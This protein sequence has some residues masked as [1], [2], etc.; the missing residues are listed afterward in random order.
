MRLRNSIS[1]T[2]AGDITQPETSDHII[3]KSVERFSRV[4]VLVNNAGIFQSKPFTEYSLEEVDA[5]LGYLR[6]TFI[7]MK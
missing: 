5:F 4:D 3:N 2:L 1:P 6:G 7:L